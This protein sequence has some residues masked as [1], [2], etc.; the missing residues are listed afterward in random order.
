MIRIK[1]CGIT[2][3]SQAEATAESGVNFLGLVFAASGG[4]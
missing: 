3:T 2:D 1:V 4:R